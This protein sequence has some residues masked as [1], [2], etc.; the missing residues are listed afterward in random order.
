MICKWFGVVKADVLIEA[1]RRKP[2]AAAGTANILMVIPRT[3][4]WMYY[5]RAICCG[6]S[7][8]PAPSLP[9]KRTESVYVHVEPNWYL[10]RM[11]Y[12]SGK[13]FST[14]MHSQSY[15]QHDSL[16]W[17]SQ[18]HGFDCTTRG[19]IIFFHHFARGGRGML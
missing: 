6:D 18:H 10:L 9:L 5:G 8:T 4:C 12:L 14:N 1:S 15:F 13:I 19:V 16:V 2:A 7:A 17:Y 11:R 3:L